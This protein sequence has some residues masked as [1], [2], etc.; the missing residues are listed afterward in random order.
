MPYGYSVKDKRFQIELFNEENNKT[1][2]RSEDFSL[3]DVIELMSS[4]YYLSDVEGFEITFNNLVFNEIID[5]EQKYNKQFTM[6]LS[7]IGRLK[8][9][10]MFSLFNKV[11][12]VVLPVIGIDISAVNLSHL[13]NVLLHQPDENDPQIYYKILKE[14]KYVMKFVSMGYAYPY[15]FGGKFAENTETI[16]LFPLSSNL[17]N[18]GTKFKH[19]E[20]NYLEAASKLLPSEIS[21]HSN[22][23]DMAGSM[24]TT[25]IIEELEKFVVCL[26]LTP[27]RIDDHERV[28]SKIIENKDQ[29]LSIIIVRIKSEGI[30]DSHNIN[31]NDVLDQ[32]DKVQKKGKTFVTMFEIDA[33]ASNS[34]I[35]CVLNTIRWKIVRHIEA[36]AERYRF[37]LASTL[38]SSDESSQFM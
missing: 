24:S 27:G 21:N 37:E 5:S 20:K 4:D 26:H 25:G 23:F 12:L 8:K 28:I 2:A 9:L 31:V 34:E 19:L 15:L 32:V 1:I 33:N 14:F 29:P 38:L 7:K 35:R 36:Y 11:C 10:T 3:K 22:V 30:D 13:G 17:K 6:S 16:D 18:Q